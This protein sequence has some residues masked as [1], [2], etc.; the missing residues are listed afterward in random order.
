MLDELQ[1][2]AWDHCILAPI[3]QVVNQVDF[4]TK[5]FVLSSFVK[6]LRKQASTG[7]C[8]PKEKKPQCLL[9]MRKN[10]LNYMEGIRG[11]GY[12]NTIGV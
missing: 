5:R 10:C 9:W 2:L 3:R 11:G 12:L 4:A 1:I 8:E 7:R 6:E